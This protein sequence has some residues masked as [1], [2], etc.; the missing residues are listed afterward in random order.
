[1]YESTLPI[2]TGTPTVNYVQVG[3]D[4]N[5][6]DYVAL[7]FTCP[8]GDIVLRKPCQGGSTWEAGQEGRY[9]WPLL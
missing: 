7:T 9:C 3:T 4:G 6:G 5:D 1:M 2:G 8:P